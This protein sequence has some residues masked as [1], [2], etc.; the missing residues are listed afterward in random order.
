MKTEWFKVDDTKSE[1]HAKRICE[2]ASRAHTHMQETNLYMYK[3]E[4]HS[5]NTHTTNIF[6]NRNNRNAKIP[7]PAL[8]Y[9]IL[10]D[11][12]HTYFG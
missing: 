10:A 1:H 12:I 8:L 5:E 2:K 9:V 6:Y 7:I 4:E 3:V 11:F